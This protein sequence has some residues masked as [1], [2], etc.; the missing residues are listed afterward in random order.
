M[1]EWALIRRNELVDIPNRFEIHPDFLHN[2]SQDEF[3][4]AFRQ[5]HDMYYQIYTDMSESPEAFGFPLYCVGEYDYFSKEAGEVRTIPW[6]PFY[7]LLCL[8]ACGVF[9]G[10]A[11]VSDTVAVRKINKAKK[12]NLLLKVLT[13]YGFV[14]W[15]YKVLKDDLQT[16]MLAQGCDYVADKMHTSLDK[17]VIH[18]ID[19]VLTEQGFTVRKG[20]PNEGP[21]VRYYR[22]RC[23]TLR[24]C[25]IRE[26]C[27]WS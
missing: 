26:N 21:A 14:S 17:E 3:E 12:T 23:M 20:D 4:S 10:S 13:E 8:F 24:L 15:N 18:V 2:L 5:I 7:L 22:S 27:F 6:S 19:K 1:N 11:F 9:E 16:S 25:L